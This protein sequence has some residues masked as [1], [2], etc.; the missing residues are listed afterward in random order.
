MER[1]VE[2]KEQGV[3]KRLHPI[4][5]SLTESLGIQRPRVQPLIFC[6]HHC[7]SYLTQRV[8]NA[9]F[10]HINVALHSFMGIGTR[11]LPR[12]TIAT[13]KDDFDTIK[14]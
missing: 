4:F 8:T 13:E 7:P 10:S 9:Y 14:N 11:G 3:M 1:S 5:P 12:I 6:L 2:Q